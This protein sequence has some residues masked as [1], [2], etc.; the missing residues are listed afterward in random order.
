MNGRSFL[1]YFEGFNAAPGQ[2]E[3]IT[4]VNDPLQGEELT[5]P[6]EVVR[7]YSSN[8]FYENVPFEFLYTAEQMPQVE[9]MVN[10]VPAVCSGLECGFGYFTSSYEVTD[11]SL[12]GLD[13][14]ITGTLPTSVNSIE[15]G[16]V[17][18]DD[19]VSDGSTITCTLSDEPTAGVWYPI[20]KDDYGI[21][22]TATTCP[23]TT[24]NLVIDSISPDTELNSLGEDYV[25]IYGTGFPITDEPGENLSITFSDGT[26]C[27]IYKSMATTMLCIT[28]PFSTA[29]LGLSLTVTVTVN[30]VS[31]TSLSAGVSSVVRVANTVDPSSYSPVLKTNVNIYFDSTLDYTLDVDDLYVTLLSTF[32]DT[33]YDFNVVAVDNDPDIPY[34]TFRYGGAWSGV[35]DIKLYSETY[36]LV[37]TAGLTFEAVGTITDFFPSTIGINGG[38]LITITGYHFGDVD[39][40]NPVKVGRYTYCYVQETS[41]YEIKCRVDEEPSYDVGDE[42]LIV[43]LRTSEEA[44]CSLAD[45]MIS[46]IDTNL[47][48]VTSMTT[49][50]DETSEKHLITIAGSNFYADTAYTEFKIDGYSQI[51]Q[52]VTSTEVVVEVNST[53]G[54]SSTD[55]KLYLLEGIPDGHSIIE[56]G[57]SLDPKI[58]S[59]TPQTGSTGGSVINATVSGVGTET[60]GVTLV[61][62]NGN[63]A[64][65]EVTIPEWGIVSCLTVTGDYGF[66]VLSLEVSGTTYDCANS[67]GCEYGQTAGVMPEVTGANINGDTEIVFSGTNF[68]TSFSGF[69]S[70]AGVSAD[71]VTIDSATQATATWDLGVPIGD[72]APVLQ[73]VLEDATWESHYADMGTA[74]VFQALDVTSSSSSLECSFNGGCYLEINAVGLASTLKNSESS[75]LTICEETC[76]LDEDLSSSSTAVCELSSLRTTYSQDTFQITEYGYLSGTL[77]G[78]ANTQV[79]NVFD[80]NNLNTNEDWD[81]DCYFGMYFPEGYEGFVNEVKVFLGSTYSKDYF[82]DYLT[83]QGSDDGSTYVDLF[84]LDASIHEGWNYFDFAEGEEASYRFYRFFGSNSGSCLV[85]EVHIFGVEVINDSASTYSCTPHLSINDAVTL[86]NDVTYDGSVTPTLTSISPRYGTVY[87]GTTVTFS[88]DNFSDSVADISV[89]IDD[90]ECVVSTASL[91]EI[92]CVTGDKPGLST[93]PSLKIYV[94]GKGL[95]ATADHTFYYVYLWS[96]ENTWGGEFVPQEG[97]S[98]HIPTGMNVLFDMDSTPVLNVIIVEGAL[99]FAPDA[100]PDHERSFDCYY[101]MV[102]HG[103]F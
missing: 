80:D 8:I 17:D 53:L 86:L 13:L 73:F 34:V 58:I 35:Y 81:A 66:N 65:Q 82:V 79:E 18:C 28:E 50:W 64:C 91:T 92:T 46:V 14:T 68:L 29:S 77:F 52:S 44:T 30:G 97:D 11:V 71:S 103:T 70:F 39:T 98:V 26:V 4:G 62:S 84:T 45:C 83:F 93:D 60:T 59:I 87:G 69:A 40:D 7:A 42:E 67:V 56:G 10:G 78:S 96:D 57:I 38:A 12:S 22:P 48:T 31:D 9:V 95:V 5:Y 15:F 89:Y 76:V 102:S 101:F 36:G 16:N 27:N 32:D 1:L 74:N 88:G 23:S 20:V 94:A 49:S 63:D 61:D 21:I 51:I 100:D 3:L 25:W 54:T 2:F 24:V 85:N 99:I 90:I 47:P 75:S 41:E 6:I 19:I 55:L 33:S 37:D 72:E 43:F